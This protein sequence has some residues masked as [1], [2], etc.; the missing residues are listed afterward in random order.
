MAGQ[1]SLTMVTL[2]V[3]V[4]K[5]CLLVTMTGNTKVQQ[6]LIL[7]LIPLQPLWILLFV[8]L[9]ARKVFWDL[10]IW[11]QYTVFTPLFLFKI[12]IN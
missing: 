6:K 10:I 9:I 4:E 2:F 7:I 11:K 1:R 8:S 12:S 5:L 3:T